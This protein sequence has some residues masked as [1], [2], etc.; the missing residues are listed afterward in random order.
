[1]H[2][3][4]LTGPP[5]YSGVTSGGGPPTGF[6]PVTPR[7]VASDVSAEVDFLRVVFGA[8]GEVHADRPADIRIAT[9]W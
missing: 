5:L 6:H 2:R 7:M 8:T 9:H 3:T 4:E 1:M